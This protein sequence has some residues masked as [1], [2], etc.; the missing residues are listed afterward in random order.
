MLSRQAMH[1]TN[2]FEY[3]AATD[4]AHGIRTLKAPRGLTSLHKIANFLPSEALGRRKVCEVWAE[5]SV[6]S[7]STHTY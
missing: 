3:P 2:Q 4:N 1:V 5:E 6:S 7:P